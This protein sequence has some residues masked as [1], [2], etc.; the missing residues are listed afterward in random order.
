VTAR[1]AGG[2]GACTRSGPDLLEPEGA[3]RRASGTPTA[4]LTSAGR[5]AGGCAARLPESKQLA[6]SILFKFRCRHRG[7]YSAP[8]PV[9]CARLRAWAPGS[10]WLFTRPCGTRQPA[11]LPAAPSRSL[12]HTVQGPLRAPGP[13]GAVQPSGLPTCTAARQRV[14][15]CAST[16]D[17]PRWLR[18]PFTGKMPCGQPSPP[19]AC[20]AIR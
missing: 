20:R 12:S 8:C 14:A 1:R 10:G 17:F 6:G 3:A 11:T 15:V 5:E 2:H 16:A 19:S 18:D 4:A 9:G 7:M 13:S